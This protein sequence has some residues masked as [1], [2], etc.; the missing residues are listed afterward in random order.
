MSR[1]STIKEKTT[2]V[3]RQATLCFLIKDNS[4]LLA[5]KKRGFAAGKWNGAGGKP[6]EG[7]KSIE[8][9]AKREMFEETTVTP[10]KLK[11]AAVLN[12]YFETQT[13]WNQQVHVFITGEW[14][15]TPTETEE[16]APKWFDIKKIPYDQM[17]D[18]DILWLPKV[19]N[20]KIVEGNFLFDENQKMLEHDI[21]VIA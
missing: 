3:L 7:D 6:K 5:M 17:W 20:G 11:K 21:K 1:L 13:E 9:T 10:K 14:N 15:G 18:D 19:L 16:M 4:I 8:A 12:F 2:I